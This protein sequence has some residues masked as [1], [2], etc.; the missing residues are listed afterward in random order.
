MR[1][2]TLNHLQYGMQKNKTKNNTFVTTLVPEIFFLLNQRLQLVIEP[3]VAKREKTK[4]L[5]SISLF[6]LRSSEPWKQC[7]VFLSHY[8]ISRS[9]D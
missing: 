6:E 2:H 4:P 5:V 9:T 1:Y 8:F 7:R 3:S